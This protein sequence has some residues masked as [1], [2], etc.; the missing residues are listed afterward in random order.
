MFRKFGSLAAGV[1]RR[2]AL[3]L[4]PATISGS[5]AAG[6]GRAGADLLLGTDVCRLSPAP[7]QPTPALDPTLVR[8]NMTEGR[9]G[10]ATL[11]RIQ[12]VDAACRPLANV[13][14]DIWHCDAAGADDPCPAEASTLRATQFAD[15][16]GVVEYVTIF[17]GR[18]KGSPTGIHFAVT[19]SGAADAMRGAI[20][21]PDVVAAFVH[22]T[23]AP[24]KPGR[25]TADAAAT[26]ATLSECG[27]GYLA[28]VIVAVAD[29]ADGAG[30]STLH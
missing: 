2:R 4:I 14:V 19:P 23:A 13:R 1:V 26:A 30:G 11:L 5:T 24:Y 15:E 17:P 25:E 6:P 9:P 29:D 3:T 10:V 20:V 16:R 7:P 22:E 8:R 28:Q 12:V 18:V 21:F 27:E